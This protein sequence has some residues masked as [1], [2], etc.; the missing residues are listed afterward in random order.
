MKRTILCRL[1]RTIEACLTCVF[2][3]FTITACAV[4]SASQEDSFAVGASPV[5]VVEV[6]SGKVRVTTGRSDTIVVV[7][8][9]TGSSN[10]EYSATQTENTVR[11]RAKIVGT[12]RLGARADIAIETPQNTDTTIQTGSGSVSVEGVRGSLQVSTGSGSVELSG[13]RE[14]ASASTGSGKISIADAVGRLVLSTGSGAIDLSDTEGQVIASTGSGSI[15]IDRATG[16]FDLSTGSGGIELKGTLAAGTS[17]ELSCGSG[18]I[19]VEFDG[20]PSVAIDAETDRGTI[21]NKF[22]M[23]ATTLSQQGR[24]VGTI[25]E[26]TAGLKIRTGSGDITIR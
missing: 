7:A 17:N 13:V 2:L 11:V 18:S 21:R 12:N 22:S 20:S 9:I 8:D 24:L 26:G 1:A 4:G 10:I 3:I 25:G 14:G 15:S 19:M 6:D 23:S 16:S 5:L